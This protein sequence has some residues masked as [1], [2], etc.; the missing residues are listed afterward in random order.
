[1]ISTIISV[2]PFAGGISASDIAGQVGL[3][4]ITENKLEVVTA[5]SWLFLDCNLLLP[6]PDGLRY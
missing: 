1:M 4:F 2:V 5:I 6:L 3:S